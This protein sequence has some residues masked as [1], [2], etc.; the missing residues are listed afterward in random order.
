MMISGER[1]FIDKQYQRFIEITD[2]ER[3]VSDV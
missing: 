1:E 2:A 3:K